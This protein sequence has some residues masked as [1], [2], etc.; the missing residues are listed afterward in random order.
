M[1][2][3][4]TLW[5]AGCNVVIKESL[6]QYK[7]RVGRRTGSTALIANAARTTVA[8]VNEVERLSIVSRRKMLVWT[9]T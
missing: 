5:I 2:P 1:P 9:D 3:V 4:W 7:V 8:A 6:Y